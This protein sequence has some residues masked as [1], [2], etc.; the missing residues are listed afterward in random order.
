MQFFSNAIN[1]VKI[2]AV[3]AVVKGM[4]GSYSHRW[5]IESILELVHSDKGV[6]ALFPADLVATLRDRASEFPSLRDGLTC[7]E[8]LKWIEA[9]NAE[10]FRQVV[11]NQDV[12]NWLAKGWEA[13][14]TALFREEN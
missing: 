2:T 3:T 5:S 13:G 4:V 7:R 12:M 8:F 6:E 14:R 10:L 11:A 1:S 9:G